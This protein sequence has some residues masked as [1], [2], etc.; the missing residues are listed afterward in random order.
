MTRAFIRIERLGD[1]DTQREKYHI[2][3]ETEI[4]ITGLLS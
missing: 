4:G 3:V 1:I 2:K